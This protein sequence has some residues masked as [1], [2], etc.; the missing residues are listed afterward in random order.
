ME[1][2]LPVALMGGPPG[3]RILNAVGPKKYFA[4][5]NSVLSVIVGSRN[6][7]TQGYIQVNLVKDVLDTRSGHYTVFATN[8]TEQMLHVDF[9]TGHYAMTA[10]GGDTVT[11]AFAE[12][13]TDPGT[14]IFSSERIATVLNTARF[15]VTTDAIVGAFPFSIFR[16]T[17]TA[18]A[19]QP[20]IAARFFVS[21]RSELAGLYNVLIASGSSNNRGYMGAYWQLRIN[22]S[23][24]IA[25]QCVAG[26][27]LCQTPAASPTSYDYSI[28]AGASPG[29]WLFIPSSG[30]PAF[31]LR[32][33]KIG[34]RKVLL[35][36]KEFV[37]ILSAPNAPEPAWLLLTGL[38][39]SP[40]GT[41]DASWPMLT[42]HSASTA[43]TFGTAFTNAS[44]YRTEYVQPNGTSAALALTLEL[45]P[46]SSQTRL[47]KDVSGARFLVLQNGAMT[48]MMP[49]GP[50]INHL[51]IG[52][53]D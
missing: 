23:G 9:D 3:I 31:A 1:L 4:M 50:A 39:E 51:H 49:M 21:N 5:Q 35:E 10:P 8:G 27:L 25:T 43:S 22:D 47:G 2:T 17:P 24:T 34:S 53:A 36:S 7:E 45:N 11:G 30:T 32:S 13:P 48:L 26:T 38:R 14:Y 42:M 46:G 15:R 19:A 37:N 18:Y 16:S 6:P 29:V 28:A 52:L 44:S 20:F 40:P 12:D 41:E 33:A